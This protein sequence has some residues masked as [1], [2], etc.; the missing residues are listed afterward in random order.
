MVL[1][2][3]RLRRA[4]LAAFLAAFL[5]I[6]QGGALAFNRPDVTPLDSVTSGIQP[7][8]KTIGGVR[9]SNN[10]FNF[11]DKSR[12]VVTTANNVIYA[13]DNIKLKFQLPADQVHPSTIRFTEACEIRNLIVL[14]GPC[15]SRE[16]HAACLFIPEGLMSKSLTFFFPLFFGICPLFIANIRLQV[17][18]DIQCGPMPYI[19]DGITWI[20]RTRRT[21]IWI[22]KVVGNAKRTGPYFNLQPR[23][24]LQLNKTIALACE[25]RLLLSRIFGVYHQLTCIDRVEYESSKGDYSYPIKPVIASHIAEVPSQPQPQYDCDRRNIVDRIVRND[26]VLLA[27]DLFWFLASIITEICGLHLI[28][29]RR[30]FTGVILVA[31]GGGAAV[32]FFVAP[33]LGIDL[34]SIAWQWNLI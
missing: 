9:F 17:E 16:Q 4:A 11:V 28:G 7:N 5:L 14:L 12:L 26:P 29:R 22:D 33:H 34:L 6:Y 2:G 27:S 1:F 24:L 25:I 23:P 3:L 19:N 15:F 18:S 10:F 30:I 31:T 20:K 32:Y 21:I 13:P 8:I